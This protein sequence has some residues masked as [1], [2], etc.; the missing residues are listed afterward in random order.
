LALDRPGFPNGTLFVIARAARDTPACTIFKMNAS[1]SPSIGQKLQRETRRRLPGGIPFRS[2]GRGDKQLRL[3]ARSARLFGTLAAMTLPSDNQSG[4]I[5]RPA[6]HIPI[7]S[8]WTHPK[9]PATSPGRWPAL[10]FPLAFRGGSSRAPPHCVE[11][12]AQTTDC[13]PLAWLAPARGCPGPEPERISPLLL[14]SAGKPTCGDPVQFLL[15]GFSQAEAVPSAAVQLI[16]HHRRGLSALDRVPVE[17]RSMA[18]CW[19]CGGGK[20]ISVTTTGTHVQPCP[21]CGG[22]GELPAPKGARDAVAVVPNAGVENAAP[23]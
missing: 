20:T 9:G 17:V 10:F 21:T 12:R 13:R 6:R 15:A 4:R 11:G 8:A 19:R 2:N 3:Q 7:P 16:A 14:R 23:A 18:K 1:G 5:P 22:S